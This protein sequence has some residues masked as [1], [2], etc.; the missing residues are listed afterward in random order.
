MPLVAASDLLSAAPDLSDFGSAVSPLLA[1]WSN[2]GFTN[3][4]F[5]TSI[6]RRP[7]AW[8]KFFVPKAGPCEVNDNPPSK[9]YLN[10]AP[11]AGDTYLF[12]YRGPE[13]VGEA[14]TGLV[15]I[16]SSDDEAGEGKGKVAWIDPGNSWIYVAHGSFGD[17]GQHLGQF[18]YVSYPFESFKL[19]ATGQS[20][21]KAALSGGYAPLTATFFGVGA[22]SGG[23]Y[24]RAGSAAGA[25]MA[26]APLSAMF[27]RSARL[28]PKVF[29]A[30]MS[31]GTTVIG[32]GGG[33]PVVPTVGQIW[34]RGNK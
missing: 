32:G 22:V 20:S 2:A 21:V 33:G 27:V 1:P 31:G 24:R 30:S 10:Y 5:E 12:V 16:G 17:G 28:P 6:G 3:S 8:H 7:H 26:P 4:T 34:P 14:G 29:A 19:A 25:S 18:T 13:L 11:A 9:G 23:L 15:L